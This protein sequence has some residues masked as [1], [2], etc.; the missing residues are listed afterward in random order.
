MRDYAFDPITYGFNWT[1]DGW[2]SYTGKLAEQQARR[3]RDSFAKAARKRGFQVSCSTV[4]SL[5]TM[6]GIG[7][8]H[9][10]IS[11][12]VPIYRAL[13]YGQQF[14][15]PDFSEFLENAR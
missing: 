8:G 14:S 7:S 4:K 13:V 3:E 2:Y 10:E 12:V 15:A 6:G 11:L 5:R 9:P 1:T